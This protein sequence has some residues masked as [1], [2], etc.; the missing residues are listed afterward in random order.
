MLIDMKATGYTAIANFIVLWVLTVAVTALVAAA[1]HAWIEQ[2][3]IEL[4]RRLTVR[5]TPRPVHGG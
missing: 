2:P 4:A 5:R 3:G 1:A